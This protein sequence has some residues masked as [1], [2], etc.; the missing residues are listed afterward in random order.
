MKK[1]IYRVLFIALL[2]L[3]QT[4]W[5]QAQVDNTVRMVPSGAPKN[6][7]VKERSN[8]KNE[9]FFRH[10]NNYQMKH[11]NEDIPTHELIINLEYDNTKYS[12]PRMNGIAV[13]NDNENYKPKEF[14]P[15]R[16]N[17]SSLVFIVEEGIYDIIIQFYRK[18]SL[19]FPVNY[20]VIVKEDVSVIQ[21]TSITI[22]PEE[23]TNRIDFNM[24]LPNGKS[25][26]TPFCDYTQLDENGNWI[27]LDPG[28]AHMITVDYEL[29]KGDVCNFSI[30]DYEVWKIDSPEE[31][32][33]TLYVNDFSDKYMITSSIVATDNEA[34]YY[35]TTF[36]TKGGKSIT[37]SNDP[38]EYI[39]YEQEFNQSEYGKKQLGNAYLYNYVYTG[40]VEDNGGFYGS[41]LQVVNMIN[42]KNKTAKG[43]IGNSPNNAFWDY[44]I[45]LS[46][47]CVETR[48]IEDENVRCTFFYTQPL[49]QRLGRIQRFNY[50]A[51][52]IGEGVFSLSGCYYGSYIDDGFYSF[53]FEE[54]SKLSYLPDKIKGI[55]GDN[56]PILVPYKYSYW[57]EDSQAFVTYINP[58]YY[59]RYGEYCESD[60]ILAQ[61]NIKINDGEFIDSKENVFGWSENEG[62]LT[63][64]VDITMTNRNRKIDGL[65]GLNLATIHY[66][67]DQEDSSAPV[68]QMLHFKDA[69]DYITDRFEAAEGAL[70]ELFAGDFNEG[71]SESNWL[72]FDRA[73]AK[74]VNVAYAPYGKDN[75]TDLTLE[76]NPEY[77]SNL[78]GWYYAASLENVTGAA[79]QGWFDLKIRLEDESGNWQEQIV[80]PA[81]QIK[82]LVDTGIENMEHP[83]W[84]MEHAE[85]VY[86]V[87]GRRLG[88]NLSTRQ[89]VNSS[90]CN[91][92]IR[93][94]RKA[95]GD[96]RKVVAK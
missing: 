45:E 29:S 43:Y 12:S 88:S 2:A 28:N 90:T 95:N 8:N 83:T 46:T 23:A 67:R 63:G 82:S 5:G 39:V 55:Q 80:S 51:A 42:S 14:K 81:F 91:K 20:C 52:S 37:L 35:T 1:Q 27:I 18:N 93:I 48:N 22:N 86:D 62:E 72:Y 26:K 31:S 25:A 38:S 44:G 94:V 78:M 61:T 70:M 11:N 13:F 6:V 84:N 17:P 3:M 76:E 64:T 30:R 71:I 74:N 41:G 75:W 36:E 19:S 50:N 66:D 4:T 10:K 89:L 85:A 32:I 24:L 65:Q 96:V 87:V 92:G 68:L 40:V 54:N 53:L 15:N 60:D 59:G 79:E 56:V 9:N 21:D 16:V 57:E 49:F 47:G 77:Y 73:K 7:I 69:E 58:C 33:N 34:N